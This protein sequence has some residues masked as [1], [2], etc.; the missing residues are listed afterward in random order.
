MGNPVGRM[1]LTLLVAWGCA[2]AALARA[3]DHPVGF[4]VGA[5]PSQYAPASVEAAVGDTV[6]FSG[7]FASHPLVWSDGDFAT[8]PSGTTKAYAFTRPGTFTFHCQLH[9]GSMFGTVHVPGDAFA[10][11]TFSWAPAAPVT[12]Q[13]V[14]FTP[15][16]FADPD[17]SVA[18]YEWDLD[19]DGFFETSGAAPAR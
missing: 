19:G 1:V 10:T 5:S 13:A 3:A 12:R 16:P 4:P 7:A 11:P 6:T 8:Q 18:R 9:P 14:T 15:G 2:P 17:G